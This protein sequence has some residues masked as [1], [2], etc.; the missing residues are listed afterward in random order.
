MRAALFVISTTLDELIFISWFAGGEVSHSG[1]CFY[2][3]LGKMFYFRPGHETLPIYAPC[4][5][6]EREE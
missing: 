3:G 1:M 2:R 6:L 4:V 5:Y